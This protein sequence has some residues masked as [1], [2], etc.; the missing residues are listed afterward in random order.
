[1]RLYSWLP[2]TLVY[3]SEQ[4]FEASLFFGKNKLLGL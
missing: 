1:M 3:T 2:S 4:E